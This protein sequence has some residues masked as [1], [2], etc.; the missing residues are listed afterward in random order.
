MPGTIDIVI[1]LHTPEVLAF[2]PRWYEGFLGDK[3]GA[4][5]QLIEGLTVEQY[6]ERLDRAG[7]QIAFIAAAKSGSIGHPS[8]WHL[9][10][11]MVHEVVQA[12]PTRFRGLAG[13]DPNEGM[14]GVRRLEYAV[15][16]LG[17]VGAHLYPHWFEMAP[18]HRKYYPFYAKC[19][20]LDVPIQMQV[21]HCLVYSRDRPLPSVGRPILLD[22][23]ACDFPE[24]KLIGIHT[25]WPWVE[26]MISVAWKHP[27]VYIG[28]DAYAPRY[29]KPEFVHFINSWGQNKVLFGT[30]FP[31]VDFERATREIGELDLR[32]ESREKLLWRNA[33]RVY[34]IDLD[35]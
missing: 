34:G 17:F 32:P 24:L 20:E 35:A 15:K 28:S 29:W 10:Y 26:E 11:E 6:L 19:V 27:N 3:I 9:P 8:N 1:N 16:E 31:I 30:D 22:T 18:D 4:E 33:A 12:Y 7:I 5:R 21:G 25:G 2:R 14:A 23:I 13:I